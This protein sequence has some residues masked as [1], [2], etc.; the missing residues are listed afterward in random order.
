[1]RQIEADVL[2]VGYEDG[3]AGDPAAAPGPCTM[4]KRAQLDLLRAHL[5]FAS[6]RGTEAT[7]LLLAAARG[8]ERLDARLA[9]ETYLA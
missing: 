2:D 3:A 6:N 1:V 7:P 5:A 9:G 4:S 8:L